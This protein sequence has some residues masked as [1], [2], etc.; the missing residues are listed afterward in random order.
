MKQNFVSTK[1]EDTRKLLIKLGFKEIQN[2][3]GLYTFL[4]DSHLRFS[5]DID[6]SKINYSNMLCI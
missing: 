4:N 5:E 2:S 3:N 1:D 6:M